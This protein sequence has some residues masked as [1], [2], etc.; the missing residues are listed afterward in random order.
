M[1]PPRRPLDA[2][3]QVSV[4]TA[5]PGQVLVM[6]YDGAINFAQKAK[7]AMLKKEIA[8]TGILIGRC[9]DIIWELLGSLDHAVAPEL[10]RQLAQLYLFVINQL[11]EANL[12]RVPEPL[13]RVARVLST[14]RAGWADAVAQT[15]GIPAPRP[16]NVGA[17]PEPAPVITSNVTVAPGAPKGKPTATGSGAPDGTARPVARAPASLRP[18]PYVGPKPGLLPGPKGGGR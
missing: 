14:L 6:L 13:D 17:P 8:Q 16:A 2:Y 7:E 3:K 15:G 18:L 4:Q 1:G 5:T 11:N 9:Q 12:K 10:C